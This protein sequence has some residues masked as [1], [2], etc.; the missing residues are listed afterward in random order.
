MGIT[1]GRNGAMLVGE[2]PATEPVPI[3]LARELATESLVAT[4]T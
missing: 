3:E 4:C 1:C 2:L